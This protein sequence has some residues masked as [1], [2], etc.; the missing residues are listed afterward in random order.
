MSYRDTFKPTN[1]VTA[2][3]NA[4][5]TRGIYSFL[6]GSRLYW[7]EASHAVLKTPA[8]LRVSVGD[9]NAYYDAAC[10]YDGGCGDEHTMTGPDHHEWRRNRAKA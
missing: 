7:D 3:F 8:G 5:A 1:I 4:D 10:D 2:K 6:D 9:G